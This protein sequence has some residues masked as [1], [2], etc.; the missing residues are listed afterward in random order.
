MNCSAPCG[1]KKKRTNNYFFRMASMP[2][3]TL[4]GADTA[5]ILTILAGTNPLRS[6]CANKV[7]LQRWISPTTGWIQNPPISNLPRTLPRLG[8]GQR[9]CSLASILS[10]AA[11]AAAASSTDCVAI[12]SE[13]SLSTRQVV[14]A[15]NSL[16]LVGKTAWNVSRRTAV[17][18]STA[19]KN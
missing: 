8:G 12:R 16:A 18:S 15:T 9:A 19:Y 2:L 11:T 1:T 17:R 7:T 10:S 14:M 13:P 5:S 6:V 4:M 3:S